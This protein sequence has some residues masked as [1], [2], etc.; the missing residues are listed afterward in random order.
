MAKLDRLR[1]CFFAAFYR[2]GAAE[3]AKK[4]VHDGTRG[5]SLQ[6]WS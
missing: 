3:G 4:I 6:W 1:H 5:P 2:W